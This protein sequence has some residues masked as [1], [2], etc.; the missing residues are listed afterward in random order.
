MS[1]KKAA[2]VVLG[3][4]ALGIGAMTALEPKTPQEQEQSRIEQQVQDLSDSQ[5]KVEERRR[6]EGESLGEALQQERNI[7][8]E[9]RPPEEPRLPHFRIRLP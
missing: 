9:H 7:P 6:A 3:V 4:A 1:V 8:G 5:E 2:A